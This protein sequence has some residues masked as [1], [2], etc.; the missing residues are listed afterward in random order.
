MSIFIRNLSLS[1]PHKTCFIDFCAQVSSGARIA[2]IGRNGSG[3]SSL[4]TMLSQPSSDIKIAHGLKLVYVPQLLHAD[5]LSGSQRLN[6]ALT[7]AFSMDPDIL[8]LD[9]PTNHLDNA[10]RHSLMRKLKNFAGILIVA[11]HD[12]ELIRQVDNIWHIEDGTTKVFLGNY[13]DYMRETK[14]ARMSIERELLKIKKDKK[15]SH[16]SLMKEQERA[17]K[18]KLKGQKSILEK[19][20]PTIVSSAKLGRSEMTSGRKTAAIEQKKQQLIKR[21]ED[22]RLPE[23]ITPKFF[24]AKASLREFISITNGCVSYGIKP[25]LS[26]INLSLNPGSRIA[27]VGKNAC[28]KSTLVKALIKDPQVQISGQWQVPKIGYLDQHYENLPPEHTAYEIIKAHKPLW[29]MAQVRSHLNDFLFRK[30]E[31]VNN[32]SCYL[33]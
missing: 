26:T 15:S 2:I 5:D 32:P 17:A 14:L 13:D 19:K 28:G 21:L 3:K 8:L 22:L 29:S 33:G 25:V 6:Q 24:I 18:S 7:R 27:I 12:L 1:F 4:L 11:T 31:E 23:V 30:N 10:N 16:E 20:W 9:E